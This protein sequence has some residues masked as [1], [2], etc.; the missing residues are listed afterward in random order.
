MGPN[1]N[2]GMYVPS[3]VCNC[4]LLRRKTVWGG[5]TDKCR[6][7]CIYLQTGMA[8]MLSLDTA[9]LDV[10]MDTTGGSREGGRMDS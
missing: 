7:V 10:Q 2:S 1:A 8:E 4:I 3:Y 6:N 9:Y 5:P